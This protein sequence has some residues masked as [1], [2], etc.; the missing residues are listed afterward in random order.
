MDQSS[1]TREWLSWLTRVRLLTILL[2]FGV[3]LIWPQFLPASSSN[4]TFLALLVTWIFLAV[5]YIA[6][7]RWL[8]MAAWQGALQVASDV[9]I[10]STLVYTTGLQESS[11]ISLYLLVIIVASILFSR[12]VAFAT[13]GLCLA[14]L[15]GMAALAFAGRIPRYF[16]IEPTTRRD[17]APGFLPIS[18][19]SSRSPT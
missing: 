4:R 10:V 15:G 6:F 11:F 19:A 8:P 14:I 5:V 16:L 7:V 3:G 13:A 1:T 12:R 2:I 9:V 17:C 18:S